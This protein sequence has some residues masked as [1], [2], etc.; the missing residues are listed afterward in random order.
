MLTK[1]KLMAIGILILLFAATAFAQT[2]EIA[3][4]STLNGQGVSAKMYLDGTAFPNF[5][6]IANSEGNLSISTSQ[7]Q[8]TIYCFYTKGLNDYIGSQSVYVKD[9]A[10]TQLTINLRPKSPPYPV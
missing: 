4:R 1:T 3:A 5:I 6:G 7:G 8:H 10:P 2:G 9:H